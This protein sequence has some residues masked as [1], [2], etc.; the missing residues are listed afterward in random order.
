MK[1]FIFIIYNLFY[2]VISAWILLYA[3]SY[4]NGKIIPDSFRWENGQIKD[5]LILFGISSL[6]I[7]LIEVG[8]LGLL[9]YKLNQWYTTN[10]LSIENSVSLTWWATGVIIGVLIVIVIFLNVTNY[11]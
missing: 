6:V 9:N 5:N 4:I 2:L 1:T 11:G 8:L 7:L 3:N 10:I